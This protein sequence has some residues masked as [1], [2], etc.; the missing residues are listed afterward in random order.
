MDCLVLLLSNTVNTVHV[1]G[2][3]FEMTT[4]R[5]ALLCSLGILVPLAKLK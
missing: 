5:F 4:V 2:S 1:G 3:L